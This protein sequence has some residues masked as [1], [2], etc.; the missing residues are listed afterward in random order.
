VCRIKRGR[1]PASGRYRYFFVDKKL[2][3]LLKANRFADTCEA[4]CYQDEK[5]YLYPWSHIV[6]H[7][8]KAWSIKDIL[9]VTGRSHPVTVWKWVGLGLLSYPETTKK[10][11]GDSKPFE[12]GRHYSFWRTEQLEDML[13]AMGNKG[14]YNNIPSKRELR[15]YEKYDI[16]LYAKTKDGEFVPVWEAENW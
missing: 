7:S 13:D 10:I 4:W 5:R 6:K 8:E 1:T 14:Y 16:L 12:G 11:G 15:A 3:R 2:H 9:K